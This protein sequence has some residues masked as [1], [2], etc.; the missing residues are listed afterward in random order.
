MEFKNIAQ[1]V[2]LTNMG[3]RNISHVG[4]SKEFVESFGTKVAEKFA[5]YS[6]FNIKRVVTELGGNYTYDDNNEWYDIDSGGIEVKGKGDFTIYLSNLTSEKRDRFTIA[7]ELGHYILHSEI[8]KKSIRVQRSGKQERYE[9]E[10]NWF[11]A[12][13]LMPEDKIREFVNAGKSISEMANA[14]GVSARAIDV[15]LKSLKIDY[16]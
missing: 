4:L 5:Y 7:H 16:P 3:N 10:A 2:I 14:L 6:D 12:G 11:A 8:G 9:W 13:F 1:T 15:R